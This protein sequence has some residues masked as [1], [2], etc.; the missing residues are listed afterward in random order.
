M[1]TRRS[2]RIHSKLQEHAVDYTTPSNKNPNFRQDA[3]SVKQIG[4]SNGSGNSDS[5]RDLKDLMAKLHQL[6]QY[7]E[8]HS[9]G[10]IDKDECLTCPIH[11]SRPSFCVGQK[12]PPPLSG[13]KLSKPELLE[14]QALDDTIVPEVIQHKLVEIF[15]QILEPL[16]VNALRTVLVPI[17][18]QKAWSVLVLSCGNHYVSP[19]YYEPRISGRGNPVDL[20]PFL[21]EAVRATF[22]RVQDTNGRN[23]SWD[24]FLTRQFSLQCNS[25]NRTSKSGACILELLAGWFGQEFKLP[26]ASQ[27]TETGQPWAERLEHMDS[28]H[29]GTQSLTQGVVSENESA[30]SRDDQDNQDECVEDKDSCDEASNGTAPETYADKAQVNISDYLNDSNVDEQTMNDSHPYKYHS[31]NEKSRQGDAES[32]FDSNADD[33]NAFTESDGYGSDDIVDSEDDDSVELDESEINGFYEDFEQGNAGLDQKTPSKDAR[34]TEMMEEVETFQT[35]MPSSSESGDPH[36]HAL[37]TLGEEYLGTMRLTQIQCDEILRLRGERSCLSEFSEG[38]QDLIKQSIMSFRQR[39][40][41]ILQ[42]ISRYAC[43]SPDNRGYCALL[44]PWHI[45][46]GLPGT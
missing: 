32:S 42:R 6:V 12:C 40:D 28:L 44:R 18:H 39:L 4:S 13:P 30:I 34:V 10:D 5:S 45:A 38:D 17:I 35:G 23:I 31:S 1:G 19:V 27:A 15:K 26:K 2:K 7:Y 46:N 37:R 33:S 14:A 3:S 11:L 22:G 25:T 21:H 24:R 9:D 8:G 36:H 41:E 29:L 16:D 43:I 20:T